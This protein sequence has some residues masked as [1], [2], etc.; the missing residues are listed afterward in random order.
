ML[1]VDDREPE[2]PED[3]IVLK[4]RVRAHDDA[5]AAVLQSGMDAAPLL[6]RAAAGQQGALHGGWLEVLLDIG[7]MLLG[8]HLGRSHDAGLEAVSDGDQAAEHRHHGLARP[9]IPLQQ[10]VHLV[11]AHHVRADFLDHAL[12][13]AGQGVGERIVAGMEVRADLGHGDAALAA[14]ADIF[15]LE[16]GQLQ[17][18]E[19]LEFQAVGRLLQGV[20]VLGEVDVPE[21][22]GERDEPALPQDVI[23]ERLLDFRQAE[24]QGCGLQPAHHLPGDP[25]CL[26]FLR[27]G[28]DA[29]QRALGQGAVLRHVHLRMH[30][31]DPRSEGLGFAEEQ[32][33]ASGHQALV[34]PAYPLEK[35]HLHLSGSIFDDHGQAFDGAPVDRVR[36]LG[37]DGAAG[38]VEGPPD[39]GGLQLHMREVRSHLRDGGD[40]AA[41]DIAEGIQVDQVRQGLDPELLPQEGGPFGTDPA[42]ILY[43]CLQFAHIHKDTKISCSEENHRKR[44]VRWAM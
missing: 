21:R 22:I 40:A 32:E 35:D 19:F 10:A 34:V 24:R 14:G 15:L 8:Q 33:R 29:G 11:A 6:L 25:A 23:G 44:C 36:F 30:E 26:E 38:P 28:I 3:D 18:K 42:E 20:A 9:H 31:V 43:A 39:H 2:V 37:H 7:V 17:E 4:Q 41:V 27:A 12:L 16:Q 13:G 1:F 5:D